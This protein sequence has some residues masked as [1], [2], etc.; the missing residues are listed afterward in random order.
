M[1]NFFVAKKMALSAVRGAQPNVFLLLQ[2]THRVYVQVDPPLRATSEELMLAAA[3][4]EF[5]GESRMRSGERR[6]A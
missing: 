1:R 3:K 2:R 4:G 5:P 6:S